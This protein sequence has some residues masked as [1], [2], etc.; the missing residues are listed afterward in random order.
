MFDSFC[1]SL[2]YRADSESDV[3]R[4]ETKSG[5]DALALLYT[6]AVQHNNVSVFTVQVCPR[7]RGAIVQTSAP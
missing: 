7:V 6:S 2:G 1:F 5:G 4:T 3:K